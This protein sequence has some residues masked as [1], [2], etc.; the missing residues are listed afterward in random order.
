MF[1]LARFDNPTWP[2]AGKDAF[3]EWTLSWA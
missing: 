2:I 3:L 1:D